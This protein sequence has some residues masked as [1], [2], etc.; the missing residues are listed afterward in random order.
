MSEM[1]T[2]AVGHVGKTVR[3]ASDLEHKLFIDDIKSTNLMMSRFGSGHYV[4]QFDISR[5]DFR[6]ELRKLII[7]KRI[8]S[9][10]IV[11]QEPLEKLHEHLAP[12]AMRLDDSELNSVSKQFYDT[13]EPF[14]AL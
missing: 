8:A 3:F 6:R 14:L 1:R 5:V 10:E 7:A 13:S 2:V 4:G 12:E 9:A 11:N